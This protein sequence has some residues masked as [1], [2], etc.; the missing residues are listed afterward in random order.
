MTTPH[1][2][3][4]IKLNVESQCCTPTLFFLFFRSS[5]SLGFF[6]FLLKFIHKIGKMLLFMSSYLSLLRLRFYILLHHF[7]HIISNCRTPETLI[8]FLTI[9]S[10]VYISASVEIF[11]IFTLFW[12]RAG[13]CIVFWLLYY[14]TR[15][16]N[17]L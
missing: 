3:C 7:H 14:Y 1:A 13:Q 9:T 6:L 12:I 4:L 2:N 16:F 5:F 17:L 10:T 8:K 11:E 15:Y